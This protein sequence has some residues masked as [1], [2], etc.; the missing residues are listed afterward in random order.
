[1]NV[2]EICADGKVVTALNQNPAFLKKRQAVRGQK[3]VLKQNG[4]D[5]LH[6]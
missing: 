3:H 5:K 6:F 1:M 2:L 4:R